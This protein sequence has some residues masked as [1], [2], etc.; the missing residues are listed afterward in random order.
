MAREEQQP[1]TRQ[2]SRRSRR[3]RRAGDGDDG[4]DGDVVRLEET[5]TVENEWLLE[6]WM[7]TWKQKQSAHIAASGSKR[8]LS[9]ILVVPSAVV[10]MIASPL[11]AAKIIDKY[12]AALALAFSG[13]LSALNS[14]FQFGVKNLGHQNAARRYSELINDTEE[15]LCKARRYRPDCDLTINDLKLRWDNLILYSPGVATAT[16]DDDTTMTPAKTTAAAT[17]AATTAEAGSEHSRYRKSSSSAP[18]H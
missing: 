1:T 12:G 18:P 17:T 16:T 13:I 9:Y 10:P 2:R 7:A 11:A 6:R 5:W 14:I 8:R 4:D 3:S 15:L